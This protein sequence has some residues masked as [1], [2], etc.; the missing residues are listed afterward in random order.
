MSA[1]KISKRPTDK[2]EVSALMK[3]GRTSGLEWLQENEEFAAL[4]GGLLA[5]IHPLLY[6]RGREVF[7][8]LS[9]DADL[10]RQPEFLSRALA[11]WQSP[12]S[13]LAIIANRRSVEHRDVNSRVSW[14]DLLVTMG[15]YEPLNLRLPGLGLE[16][17]YGPGT[18]VC[19]G[20]R[21]AL[22]EVLPAQGNR[23]SFAWFMRDCVHDRMGL[24]GETWH[25]ADR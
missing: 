21:L 8:R 17:A 6:D 19:L 9:E 16:L 20:G 3:G 12:W 4:C 7:R 25:K 5:I 15:Q 13:G 11:A 1:L 22:H 18:A 23:I 2:P 10:V 24:H 14:Y